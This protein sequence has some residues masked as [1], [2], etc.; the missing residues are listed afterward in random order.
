MCGAHRCGAEGSPGEGET[1]PWNLEPGRGGEVFGKVEMETPVGRGGCSYLS[2]T[3]R[4]GVMMG[5]SGL[6]KDGLP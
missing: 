4:E 2:Q 3:L 6:D 5:K 1:E